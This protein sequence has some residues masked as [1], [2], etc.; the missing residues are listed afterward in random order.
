MNHHSGGMSETMASHAASTASSQLFPRGKPSTIETREGLSPAWQLVVFI[1]ILIALFTR[2]PDLFLHP[3][4]Y[5]EDG[6]YW[7]A[8]A[9]NL[10]WARALLQPLGGYLNT[11]PRLI[12]ALTLLLPLRFAPLAMNVAGIAIQALPVTALLSARCRTWGSLPMRMLMAAIYV[13]L[14]NT[15]EIHVVL[16]NAQWHL[17]LLQVLLAFGAAPRTW[18]GRAGDILLFTIGGVSGPFSI[19]LLPLTLYFWWYRRQIWTL[20]ISALCGIGALIQLYT[21]AHAVRPRSGPVGASPQLL[22]RMLGG[23]IFLGGTLALHGLLDKLPLFVDGTF[24]LFGV[25]ILVYAL[26]RATIP[27]RLMILFTAASFIA[28]MHSPLIE[29]PKPAW[30]LMVDDFFCRYWYYPML[31]FFWSAAWCIFRSHLRL[32]KIA[33]YCILVPLLYGV[34]RDWKYPPFADHHFQL[35]AQQF[36]QARPGEPVVIPLYPDPMDMELVKHAAQR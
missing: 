9:Y 7:Y 11:L 20:V 1:L 23:N 26:L 15:S 18:I 32:A 16:T 3:Q 17:T 10:G 13:A 4:F 6:K 24:A 31:A 27:L 19:L 35:Y 5:A 14:P 21:L 12:A 8:Q 34:V 22:I 30:Q 33:G 25:A 2:R 29:G 28:A 36:E